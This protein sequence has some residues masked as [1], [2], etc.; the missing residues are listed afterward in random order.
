MSA[1]LLCQPRVG[2][3]GK[4]AS[5]IANKVSERTCSHNSLTANN[6]KLWNNLRVVPPSGL[7][8]S[9][10]AVILC[11][12]SSRAPARGQRVIYARVYWCLSHGYCLVLLVPRWISSGQIGGRLCGSAIF[13]EVTHHCG[14]LRWL[15]K[16]SR[17]KNRWPAVMVCLDIETLRFHG[18]FFFFFFPPIAFPNIWSLSCSEAVAVLL[19]SLRW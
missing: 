2:L 9:D 1:V 3:K 14:P 8:S 16:C 10:R 5:I 18:A 19:L 7:C 15:P 4:K 17:G 13:I 12:Q 6:I 11:R